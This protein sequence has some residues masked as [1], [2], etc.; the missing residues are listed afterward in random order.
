M[1]ADP[2]AALVALT[3]LGNTTT[4]VMHLLPLL[5]AGGYQGVIFHANGVGG[6]AM[7]ELIERGHVRRG[8]STTP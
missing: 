1:A 6:V 3:M 5:E 2:D 4:A 7:E 8:R